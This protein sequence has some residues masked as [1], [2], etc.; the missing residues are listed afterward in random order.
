MPKASVAR[1]IVC[2]ATIVGADACLGTTSLGAQ[3]PAYFKAL[4]VPPP[5]VGTCHEAVQETDPKAQ[6]RSAPQFVMVSRTPNARRDMSL[7]RDSTGVVIGFSDR[8]NVSTA[9]LRGE[10][11]SV[12]AA[13][14]A[15]GS[16][17]GFV[18]RTEIQMPENDSRAIDTASLRRMRD[19]AKQTSSQSALDTAGQNQVRL[20]VAWL[21]KRC[22]G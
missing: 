6:R 7:G 13:L 10:G 8:V 5:T 22:P 1:L 20:L 14:R 9:P 3:V 11:E 15:D 4:T 16:V 17:T 21:A 18:M 12:I 19:S 2:T